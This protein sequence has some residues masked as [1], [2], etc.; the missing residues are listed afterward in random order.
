MALARSEA[1][2]AVVTAH[3]AEAIFGDLDDVESIDGAFSSSGAD[4]LVN[5][6]SLGF[7]HGPAIVAAAEEAGIKRAVFVS[8]TALFTNLNAP[9]K[10][11]RTAAEDGIRASSLAWTI[12]R[13]TM[14]YGTPGDRNMWRLLGLLRRTPIVPLP[15]AGNLHQPVHVADLAAAIVAAAER[16]TTAGRAYDVAGPEPL[17]LRSVVE[18]AA[19]ALGRRVI[20]VPMPARPLIA[21]LGLI[22]RTGRRVPISAEQVA[23][24]TE[25]K[26]F[27]ISEAVADLSYAP[28]SFAEGIARESKLVT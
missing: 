3:G 18:Q 24:L 8:T 11:I 13:P 1:A 25:D 22:E 12:I 19:H 17:P 27:D 10:A 28:R 9:S 21:L 23:R 4:T 15:G 16:P 20:A 7:G 26:A 14:I 2:A 6:A 5:V